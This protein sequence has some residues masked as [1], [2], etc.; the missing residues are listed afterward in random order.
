[1]ID[2]ATLIDSQRSTIKQLCIRLLANREHSKK[3]LLNKLLAKGFQEE[4]VISVIENL[5]LEGWQSDLRY[6]ESYTRYRILKGYGPSYINYELKKNGINQFDLE[7]VVIKTAGSWL[8][9]A[10][11]V[12][13]KKY[14]DQTCL[15]RNEWAKRSRFLMQRGF[16]S[17]TINILFDHLNIKFLGTRG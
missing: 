6:A 7:S 1:M 4:S 13:L 8:D 9:L 11:K 15:E 5:A 3:D 10:E 17:N 14:D 16:T 2:N 12:Y